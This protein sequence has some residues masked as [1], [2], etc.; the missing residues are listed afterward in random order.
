MSNKLDRAGPRCTE[1]RDVEN[2]AEVRT[3]CC[4]ELSC[5]LSHSPAS[6]PPSQVPQPSGQTSG[7]VLS[8]WSGHSA[9]GPAGASSGYPGQAYPL[10]VSTTAPGQV[11]PSAQPPSLFLSGACLPLCHHFL[12]VFW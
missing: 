3:P 7:T 9:W 5:L 4:L 8:R 2:R 12:F 1:W 6:R 11:R 10:S